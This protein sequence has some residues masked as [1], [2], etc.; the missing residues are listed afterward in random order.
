MKNIYR[1][2]AQRW[3]AETPAAAKKIKGICT[4][5][6]GA[7]IVVASAYDLLPDSLKAFVP[8]TITSV[9]AVFALIGRIISGSQIVKD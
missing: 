3:H 6:A 8:Q 7:A 2:F 4:F 9:I 1:Y 5:I